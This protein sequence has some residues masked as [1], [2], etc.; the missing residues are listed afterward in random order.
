[1]IGTEFSAI[2]DLKVD[3]AYSAFLTSTEKNRLVKEATIKTIFLKYSDLDRQD[4]RDQLNSFIRTNQVFTPVNNQVYITG[5]GAPSISDYSD[6]FAVKAK[7]TQLITGLAITNATN[8]S[9]ILVTFTGTNNLRSTE[10]ITISGVIGNP[11]ANGTFYINKIKPNQFRLYSNKSLTTPVVGTGAY[12][13]GGTISRVFYNSCQPLVSDKKIDPYAQGTMRNPR[14]E[15]ADNAIKIYPLTETCSEI[16]ADYLSVPSS[17]IDV[18]N[19]STDLELVYPIDL[20]YDIADQYANLFSQNFKD[21]ELFQTSS[22]E[23]QKNNK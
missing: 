6:L 15:I 3:K 10:Q 2:L 14:F 13:S 1:M 4:E 22:F 8:A 20:L 5:A 12:S 23:I 19:S 21:G 17:Y 7:F 16:T 9:P 11:A 18:T